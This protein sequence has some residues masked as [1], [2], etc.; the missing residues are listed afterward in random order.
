MSAKVATTIDI[1]AARPAVW[2][3]LTDFAAYGEWNSHMK[4]EG[5]P[6]VGTKLV[7]HMGGGMTFKPKVLVAKPN[8]EL[9]WIGKLA[10]GGL[11][12][13]EH[14]FI[15]AANPDGTTRLTHGEDFSGAVVTLMGRSLRKPDQ[16]EK[17][18][19]GYEAFN[20]ALKARVEEVRARPA[21]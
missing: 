17:N 10:F 9:R 20:R 19:A 14:F 1:D 13:G 5:V 16:V 12:D 21:T 11:V 15:L 2:D 18:Q 6:E 8:H 7:V 4:I 3:V